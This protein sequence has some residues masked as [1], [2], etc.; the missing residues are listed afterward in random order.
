VTKLVSLGMKRKSLRRRLIAPRHCCLYDPNLCAATINF[1]SE[2]FDSTL[3]K[4]ELVLVDFSQ[5]QEMTAGAALFTFGNISAVQILTK[6][7]HSIE[8]VL[9]KDHDARRMM[10]G[11]GLWRAL[12]TGPAVSSLWD[13]PSEYLSGSNP[14]GDY[15]RT[16]NRLENTQGGLPESVSRAI[17]EAILNVS[18]H[19]YEFLGEEDPLT[20]SLGKRWWQNHIWTEDGLSFLIY[21]RGMSIPRT[22]QHKAFGASPVNL[23]KMAMTAGVS[24]LKDNVGR[25]I[26]S[27]DI[28]RPVHEQVASLILIS[29][30]AR[31]EMSKANQIE[32][33]SAM[34]RPFPGTLI[35]WHH[36]LSPF[37]ANLAEPI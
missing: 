10:I 1:V 30:G 16:L 5:L 27:E 15:K 23:L 21:D 4:G 35:E 25:G 36:K 22:I 29:G 32:G 17:N 2:I 33:F 14:A 19:A 8:M 6:S 18:H 12:K 3:R 13:S 24:R 37:T 11:T 7:L 34:P 20:A 9:P 26:G 31:F 28:K